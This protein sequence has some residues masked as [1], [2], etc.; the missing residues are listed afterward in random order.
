MEAGHLHLLFNHLPV[1]G[2]IIGALFLVQGIFT[3]A[4]SSNR[5]AYGIFVISAI[6]ATI[7]YISGEPAEE[8]LVGVRNIS[9]EAVQR[10]KDFA[11]Y[12]LTASVLLGIGAISAYFI[13]KRRPGNA[14]RVSFVIL[15]LSLLSFGLV[16]RTN[17]L[18]GE[19]RHPA[20]NLQNPE[21]SHVP[22]DRKP[23]DSLAGKK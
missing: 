20:K 14:R 16:A 22:A 6:G 12:A 4:E 3:R 17:Y 11:V 15:F 23:S 1:F 18:G 10:H 8:K 13:S 19:I 21:K 9:T 2:S 7:S 5:A